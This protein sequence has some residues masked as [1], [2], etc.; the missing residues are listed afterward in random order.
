MTVR[1][2]IWG[3]STVTLPISSYPRD[4]VCD[5]DAEKPTS[6]L[7]VGSRCYCVDTGKVYRATAANAWTEVG[8]S[9]GSAWGG[10]TGTLSNQSDL[11]TALNAKAASGHNHDGVYSLIGHTHAGGADPFTA[12]VKSSAD[13]TNATTTPVAVPGCSFAFEA[14]STYAIELYALCTS[15]AAT[16]GYGF[17][18]DVSIA[19]TAVGLTFFHQLAN[20]GTLAGGSSLADNVTAGVSSGVPAINVQ[21]P[22]FGGGV[23]ITG[24]NPGT[25]Q[26]VFRPEVAAS[27]TCKA[28]TILRVMKVS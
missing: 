20:T 28:G 18:L 13:V 21:N 26:L 27:A 17:A 24:V 22:V 2:H 14:N 9:G 4:Y 19:V 7:V 16:T 11:Q 1:A 23:L 12:K 3:P 6:G 5:T 8:G 15:A 25:A 10:I